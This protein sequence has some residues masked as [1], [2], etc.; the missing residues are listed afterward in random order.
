MTGI[1]IS[2]CHS[3]SLAGTKKSVWQYRGE[4]RRLQRCSPDFRRL[5]K[6]DRRR[7]YGERRLCALG[8]VDDEYY[9][10]VYT[11]LGSVCWIISAWKVGDDGKRRY[12][13][14]LS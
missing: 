6:E 3:P 7:D 9:F 4:R 10:V 11:P 14:I 13:K 8:V 12:E 2:T 5:I 1:G